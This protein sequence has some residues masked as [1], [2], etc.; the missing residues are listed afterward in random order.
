M[1]NF[2]QKILIV[3]FSSLGDIV[4]S[5]SPLKTIRKLF[6]NSQITFLTL[7]E[8]VPLLEPTDI[9]ILV[10]IKRGHRLHRLIEV[11][12]YLKSKRFNIIFDLHNSIRSNIVTYQISEKIFR[13]KKPRFL[14]YLLFFFHINKFSQNFSIFR[15]TMIILD[16]F[17]IQVM[18]SL[19]LQ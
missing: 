4:Q 9:D 12:N 7:S 19:L 3:R 17:G 14:R 16:L 11:R 1:M 15:L 6:T 10:S 5:T 18:E 2:D 8:Y 13:I